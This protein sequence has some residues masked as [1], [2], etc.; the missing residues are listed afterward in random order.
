MVI[1][2]NLKQLLCEQ[3]TVHPA[4]DTWYFSN[5][6]LSQGHYLKSLSAGKAKRSALPY[7]PGESTPTSNSNACAP[8]I[9]QSITMDLLGDLLPF[10]LVYI[11]DILIIQSVGNTKEVHLLNVKTV[12]CRQ[13]TGQGLF[14]PISENA[15][16]CKK[17]WST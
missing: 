8:D 12:L 11:D 7:S 13:T 2:G 6:D 9:F 10:A 4:Q 3:K 16:L 1:F 14:E 17:K 5:V 15:S